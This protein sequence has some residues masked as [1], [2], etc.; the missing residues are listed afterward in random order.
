MLL[1]LSGQVL[2]QNLV[3]TQSLCEAQ[4]LTTRWRHCTG[5]DFHMELSE[6]DVAR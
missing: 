6:T 1:L 5:A 4:K 2:A 3:L